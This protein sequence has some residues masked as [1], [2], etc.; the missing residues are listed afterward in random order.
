[1]RRRLLLTSV[2]LTATCVAH[3]LHA[4][5]N[6]TRDTIAGATNFAR[7]ETTVACAGA[8]TPEAMADIR[9]LGFVAVVNLRLASEA[10]ANIDAERAA[11]TAAGLRYL[12]IPL[13]GSSPD[14]AAVDQFLG[15]MGDAANQP[16]FIH[17]ASGNRAAAVWMIKRVALDHWDVARADEEARALGLTSAPLRQFVDDYLKTHAH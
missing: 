5:S 2:F 11:A 17:C 9:K 13:S 3:A 8:T 15:A 10:G 7:V 12:H 14:P 6:V 4:Q 1:M 16:A